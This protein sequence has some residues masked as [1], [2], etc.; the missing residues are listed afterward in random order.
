AAH[1]VAESIDYAREQWV[2]VFARDRTDLGPGHAARAAAREAACYARHRP[3]EIALHELHAAWTA[4][5]SADSDLTDLQRRRVLLADVVALTREHDRIVP[6]LK[7]A[8]QRALLAAVDLSGPAAGAE[9][10]VS[11]QAARIADGL[12]REWEQERPAAAR[13][14]YVVLDGIGRLGQRLWEVRR[15]TEEL[16][17]WSVRWQPYLPEMP[18]STERVAHYATYPRDPSRILDAFARHAL[19]VAEQANPGY[20]RAQE[21]AD[22]AISRRDQAWRAYRDAQDRFNLSGYGALAHLDDPAGRLAEVD[23]DIAAARGRL[24]SAR[25]QI[26]G[27]RAEPAL[28]SQPAE[29]LELA[30][31]DWQ[32]DRDHAA[33]WRN[34]LAAGRQDRERSRIGY[35]SV[36]WGAESE[37]HRDPPGRGISR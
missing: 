9:A 18:T 22:A 30:R 29:V 23:H 6:P 14:G 3:L 7:A 16:A 24:D 27:L 17:R 10:R 2:A 11:A 19:Q 13:A 1:L 5:A 33:A 8:Y 4:E 31:A 28:R 15:A 26:A 12:R 25:G 37:I 36:G 20:R 35:G 21:H 34:L 32:A